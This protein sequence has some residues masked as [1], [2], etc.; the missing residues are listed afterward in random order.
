MNIKTILNKKTWK[1]D[2]V[3]K[4]L[5]PQ[6]EY[7]RMVDSLQTEVQIGKYLVYEKIYSSVMDYYNRNQAMIQQFWHG[8]YRL[9]CSLEQI[10]QA[11]SALKAIEQYPLIMTRQQYARLSEEVRKENAAEKIDFHGIMFH[12][13][14]CARWELPIGWYLNRERQ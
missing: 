9:L 4:P 14:V 7:N 11:N 6:S 3:G 5:F 8:Y 10:Q 12:Y 13:Q 2:E 1:G